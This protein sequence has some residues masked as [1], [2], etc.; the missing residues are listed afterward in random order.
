NVSLNLGW[1]LFDGGDRAALAA[2]RDAEAREAE[3]VLE[4]RR[5]EVAVEVEG[6]LAELA[7]AEAGERQAAVRLEVAGDNSEEVR[8]RFQ[9]GL[10]TALEQADA[11]VARFEAEAELERQRFAVARARL[12]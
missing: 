6:A 2:Q 9:N 10:A 4:R 1:A 5:R 3:L 12:A 8:E 7:A 11:L